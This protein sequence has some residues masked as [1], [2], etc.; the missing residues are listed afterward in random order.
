MPRPKTDIEPRIVAAARRCFLDQGV[1]AASLRRIAREAKTS[2]G[3]IYYYFPNKDDLFFAVVEDVY[4]KFLA[5]LER[6]L[7]PDAEFEIRLLRLYQRI[8]AISDDELEVIRLVAREVLVS[9]SRLERLIQRFLQ[10]HVP[11][12]L[13]A[14]ADGIASGRLDRS[15]HP[16]VLAGSI[17]A[18]GIFPQLMHKQLAKRLPFL[19]GLTSEALSREL[20]EVLLRGIGQREPQAPTGGPS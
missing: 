18:L 16:M 2:L 11:L 9:S 8:G 5:D 20:V 10:G 1:D 3:M 6:A 12:V 7:S 15:R 4:A 14:V 19:Q 13:A 17:L